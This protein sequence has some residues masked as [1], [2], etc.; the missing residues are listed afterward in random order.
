[1]TEQKRIPRRLRVI[2]LERAKRY[3][4]MTITGPRQSGKTTL[5]REAFPH[6]AYANLED[7]TTR[8]QALADPSGFLARFSGGAVLDEVQRAPV[9]LSAIQ[10]AAD[11]SSQNGRFV[12]SGSHNFQLHSAIAQSL[13]GRTSVLD[14][15][16]LALDE[17]R[18]FASA[19]RDLPSTLFQGAYPR[20]FDQDIPVSEFMADYVR[21]Y[22]ERDVRL[23]LNVQDLGTFQTFLRLCAGRTGSLLNLSALA[24]DAGI[25]HV[26]AKAWIG[27]LEA[28][29]IVKRVQ[30]WHSNLGKRLVK[31]PKLHFLDSGLLC[32]LLGIRS[33]DQLETHPLRG[34]I[35]ESWVVAEVLKARA[36]EGLSDPIWFFRDQSGT[37]IDLLLDLPDRRVLV[38]TKSGA[39]VAPDGTMHLHQVADDMADD[40]MLRGR[41]ERVAVY[42]GSE[43]VTVNGVE[44]LPWSQVSDYSWR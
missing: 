12:L 39:R 21:T 26:T 29:Y 6:L 31:T 32:W 14:L 13:A 9:L 7:P 2:A 10:V 4:T 41:I 37:E 27:L 44:L 8:E 33:A 17:L 35:F 28:S 15:L 3:R 19:P 40:P 22:V 42:G 43:R 36:N 30:P 16:P 11:A 23:L 25:S 5:C 1:M 24:S 34:Q 38:E 20:I 18:Q